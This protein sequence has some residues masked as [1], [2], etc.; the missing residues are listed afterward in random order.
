MTTVLLSIAPFLGAQQPTKIPRIGYLTASSLSAQSARIEA[1]RQGLRELGYVEG[2]N[3]VIEFRYAEGKFDRLPELAAELVRLKVDV[4]VTAGPIVT[5]AAKEATLTIPIVMAQ[6]ADPVGSGFVASLARPGGNITGLATLAPE[7]SGKQLE[8]LKEIVPKLS[9]VA[10]FGTSTRPGNAQALRETELAAGAFG[11]KLQ[12]LDVL[13]PKDIETAFRAAGKGRAHAVLM[14]V[15][16][17][18]ALSQ[19][20][21]IAELA[22]KSRLPAIYVAPEF[23]E[24][25]GLMTYGVSLTDLFRRAAT[26]VD[27]ILK[28]AKPADLPVEQPKKFELVI[29]L[30]AA[31]QI[32]LTIPPNVLVRAD[33]VIK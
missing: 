30:K 3:I 7:I 31:K 22:V 9:R 23:V 8:L 13:S 4:I 18:I 6:D 5:R 26:Y 2:K 19:R 14:N 24:A 27:K 15:S 21:E 11:V 29:N 32:G 12:Y 33:K 17:G 1:F 16:G 10:V 25:G 28:G 20:T